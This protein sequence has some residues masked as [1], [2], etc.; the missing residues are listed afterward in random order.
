[1]ATK[2]K[3]NEE[4]EVE[5][6]GAPDGPLLDLSDDAVKKMIK[7]AKK[8]GYV[9]M[10]ELNAV[11]PSEEVTSE[12]IEDTMAML[13]DMGINVVEDDEQDADAEEADNSDDESDARELADATGTAVAPTTTK[14]EP[15]DRTDDPVRMYLREMGT[16]ELLSREGEIAI[17]KRIE[18][19]R[20]TM[21]S[22]LCESPL[23]FQAIIIW[24]DAL[25][26]S[27][28]LL[29][30]I[31]DLETTYAG[32]EAKQA[33]VIERVE[34][35]KP[36]AGNDRSR[37]RRDD[38]DI[39]NVGGDTPVEDDDDEDDEANL[40][41]AAMEA[42]LRPQ[43]ME[44]LDVIADT[45]KKLRKLQDQQV[46]NRLAASGSLS[47]SQERRYKELK[48]QL[49]KAVKS[50]SLNQNRIEALVAQL[51]DINKRLV[52][53]EGRLL[54]LAES[55]GVR[56]EDFLKEYQGN[57]LD[58]N[59]LKAVSNLTT[60][61]WKEFTKNEKDTIKNLR[62][63]IQNMAQETAISISEFRRIVNQVQKGER[64]AALAKKEMVEANLRLV[65]SIAK[66]YTN[67][68]LQFLDLIQEGNIGL[69][70]AVDKF[71]YRR[72]YKFSTYAT[73][74]IRQAITRSIADQARTI[75][76]PVHMIETINKIVRTSRQMLHEIGREPTPEE[77]AEKLAMPLEKV[78]KV[79][80][81][82]KEP[83]SLETP[84]GDE[85]DSHLGDFIE[86]KNALLPIDAAIQANLRDTTTRVLASLTPRE[87]RVLRMRFGI[88]MNTD[89]T[90]EEV[91]QQFSV[92]RERIRQIEAKALRKLK[93][94]SRSRKLRSFL[95][96]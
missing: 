12:Q 64:E 25:N 37:S 27:Q 87:E 82:A 5:R 61:G 65:I 56:R 20:E 94:P 8:R 42:E 41:L 55:Y 45:Y 67:R 78:R 38:D 17:A 92:T 72:G 6:E 77:L 81:I 76:I 28:I 30:E 3:E 19:G 7:L 89:H 48:D 84:V 91:G 46:E 90:L 24:R 71:E 23:T 2:A 29:R 31:I 33:P 15:T 57:E 26:D 32:P 85:E 16:V 52:Q 63:E 62:T 40:S 4:V 60:R 14:K 70:K 35:E 13:S 58:P 69:M 49:I 66:K 34:E 59:W 22:G 18:A 86:D 53:N 9:T 96:S 88:G 75:R 95:D 36:A 21:I 50:L 39:T 43:V 74:W 54:R 83:I 47:P 44:T 80:K 79:L 10:D 68:G 51:Y 11:L 1:M 73:W 93:H